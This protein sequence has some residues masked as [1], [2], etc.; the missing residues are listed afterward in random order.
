[1]AR[2]SVKA[3]LEGFH[4][5]IQRFNRLA[6]DGRGEKWTG[7][8]GYAAPY[9][10]YVHNNYGANFKVGRAGFLLDVIREERRV[11]GSIAS[12]SLRAGATML[13]RVRAVLEYIK[14]KSQEN[15]PVDTGFLKASAFILLRKEKG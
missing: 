15:C 13:Q 7:I 12:K 2:F 1:M 3:K 14:K 11:L 5:T 6:K 4:T 10:V 9:A 8:V